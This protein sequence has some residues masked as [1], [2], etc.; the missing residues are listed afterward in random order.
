MEVIPSSTTVRES[1]VI[2]ACIDDVWNLCKN[3]DFSWRE[4]VE[5]CVCENPGAIDSIRTVTYQGGVTQTKALRGLNSYDHTATWEMITSEPSVTYSS[6]RYSFQLHPVTT[7]KQTFIVF[8]TVYSNDADAQ[9][10]EDQKYKLR[11]GI[12]QIQV[13]LASAAAE[14]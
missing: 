8:Q 2:D 7:S 11:E 10:T 12:K 9:V 4:D 14:N 3:V 13:K 5:N 6:A 1:G